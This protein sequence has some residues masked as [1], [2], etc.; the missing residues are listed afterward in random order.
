MSDIGLAANFSCTKGS[1]LSGTMYNLKS[2]IYFRDFHRYVHEP[3]PF[4]GTTHRDLVDPEM[5]NLAANLTHD[6]AANIFNNPWH[7]TACA[8]LFNGA[9]KIDPDG[10]NTN[11]FNMVD[12]LYYF[13]YSCDATG[14]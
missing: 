5:L 13:M 2:E 1:D 14:T 7:F 9:Y 6:E 3:P 10:T 11:V 12:G 4:E 8:N